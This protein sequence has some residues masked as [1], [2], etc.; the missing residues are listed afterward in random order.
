MNNEVVLTWLKTHKKER[1]EIATYLRLHPEFI[2]FFQEKLA[3]AEGDDLDLLKE[4]NH[5]YIGL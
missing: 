5:S 3:E 4:V 2:P 1:I